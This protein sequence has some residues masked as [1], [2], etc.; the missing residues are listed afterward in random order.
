LTARREP[1]QLLTVTDSSPAQP[2]DQPFDE[3]SALEELEQL[4]DKIQL[5][6]RQREQKVAEFDV[7]VRTFRHDRYA[8]SI[9]ATEHERRAEDRPAASG[10]VTHAAGA[11]VPAPNAGASPVSTSVA[12][13]APVPQRTPSG[14]AV[15]F[16]PVAHAA[17]NRPVR[18]RAAYIG[19][20][21]AALAVVLV[22]VLLW[23]STGAP[24]G[25]AAQAD[26]RGVAAPATPASASVAAPAAPA[27]APTVPAGPPKAL[28]VEFVTVRPVWAR[29]TVDGRR[30]MER[31]FKAD[32][33]IP[34]S[35]DR[36][37]VIR[38]GDAGAIRL[39]VDGKDLGVLGRDGQIFER[40]FTPQAK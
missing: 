1:G 39:V 16:E 35:A 13:A 22:T 23:R 12:E 32:Q 25:P 31:E 37:F 28:N 27:P 21:L 2:F 4:V 6:R 30:A 15:S 24:V 38:A 20:A 14:A 29:I 9:A 18:P 5:S 33:R 26:P 40:T 3:R 10:A 19:V 17:M 34:F 36:A 7:F 11:V 8:A